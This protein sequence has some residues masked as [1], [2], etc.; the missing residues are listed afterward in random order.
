MVAGNVDSQATNFSPGLQNAPEV[1]SPFIWCT[2]YTSQIGD[3][4]GWFGLKVSLKI[5]DGTIVKHI[6]AKR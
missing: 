1:V 4:D 3:D 5:G 2:M 6:G